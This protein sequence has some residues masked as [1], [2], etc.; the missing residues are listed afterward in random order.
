MDV[1]R[2][3]FRFVRTYFI[4]PSTA[5]TR[6][7]TGYQYFKRRYFDYDASSVNGLKIYY[8]FN[9]IIEGILVHEKNRSA[10][11][12]RVCVFDVRSFISGSLTHMVQKFRSVHE[13][14]VRTDPEL[15]S[16]LSNS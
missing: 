9:I 2:A 13:F 16:T 11:Q 6:I 1:P 3:I 8:F 5:S 10:L 12:S 7:F 14:P 4:A 15:S